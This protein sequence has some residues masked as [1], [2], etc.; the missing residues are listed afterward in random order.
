M[1]LAALLEAAVDLWDRDTV[2]RSLRQQTEER[3]RR[4]QLGAQI[5][6]P[7][8]I[9]D[10][11]DIYAFE[12]PQAIPN[13]ITAKACTGDLLVLAGVADLPSDMTGK[14]VA[15]ENADPGYD[16][17]FALDIGGL[18]TAYG[19]PN[20]H[21]AIRASEFGLP[22]VIGIGASEFGRLRSGMAVEIDCRRQVFR[23]T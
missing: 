15:I 1:P 8:F 13:F 3:A 12:R 7:P 4:H 18:V 20:S 22:A 21:M 2:A 23:I 17:L 19:G 11:D 10:A 5:D 9:V 16:Y 6:L 14:I